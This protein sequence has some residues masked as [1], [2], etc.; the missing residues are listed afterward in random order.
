MGFISPPMYTTQFFCKH[1]H[2]VHKQ[3]N[4]VYEM[5]MTCVHKFFDPLLS[6]VKLHHCKLTMVTKVQPKLLIETKK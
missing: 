1:L 6:S 5:F 2:K 3:K 4:C